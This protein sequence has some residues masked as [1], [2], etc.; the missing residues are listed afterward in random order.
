MLAGS[1]IQA[2]TITF[3][4]ETRARLQAALDSAA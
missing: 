2:F 4:P 1:K 3:T